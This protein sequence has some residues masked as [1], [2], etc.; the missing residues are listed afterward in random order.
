MKIIPQI[1][2][3]DKKIFSTV[4]TF[5]KKYRVASVLKAAN[6]YKSKGIPTLSIFFY[7]FS[8]IF[9]NR[10]MYM[11]IL[12]GKNEKDFAKDTVYRFMKS[13]NI[14]WIQFTTL[15][16]G[17][18]IDDSIEHLTDNER[19]NVLIIDNTTLSVQ[20]PKKLNCLPKYM[21]MQKSSINMA[22]GC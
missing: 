4:S 8:L 12:T 13:I 15:L 18:I 21:I 6:A 17:R 20:D 14:N 7:L 10:S 9:D 19:V 5:F 3:N 22:L 2:Q 11:D 1:Y 16:A